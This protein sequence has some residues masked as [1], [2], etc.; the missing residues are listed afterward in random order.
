MAI[1]TYEDAHPAPQEREV[2]RD[3]CLFCESKLD[4]VTTMVDNVLTGEIRVCISCGWWC[5]NKR[6]KYPDH[7]EFAESGLLRHRY[8]MVGACA[9]LRNLDPSDI[10]LPL[11]ELRQYLIAKY[12]DRGFVNPQALENLVGSIFRHQGYSTEVTAYQRDGG[13]DVILSKG[14]ATIG[15]Q[16]KRQKARIEAEQIR[17]LAGALILEGHTAGVFVTTAAFRAGAIT[18]ASNFSSKGIP[19][20]LVDAHRLYDALKLVQ[21]PLLNKSDLEAF[22]HRIHDIGEDKVIYEDEGPY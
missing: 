20:E 19:I 14:T 17:A 13:I 16:V 18:A 8:S 22:V 3:T 15:V 10:S 7:D 2:M 5:R 9:Q 11:A 4:H 1:W 12:E 6:S 21:E